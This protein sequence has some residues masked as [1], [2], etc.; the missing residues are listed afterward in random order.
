MSRTATLASP[1]AGSRTAAVDGDSSGPLSALFFSRTAARGITVISHRG[2]GAGAGAGAGVG[3]RGRAGSGAVKAIPI[4]GP[5]L[6]GELAQTRCQRLPQSPCSVQD[7]AAA[8]GI[9]GAFTYLQTKGA[10]EIYDGSFDAI[11]KTFKNKGVLDFYS[12]AYDIGSVSQIQGVCQRRFG[13]HQAETWW[14]ENHEK[15]Y[16]K[17]NVRSTDKSSV[18]PP[19]SQH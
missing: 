15:V 18:S 5:K 2:N 16:D 1:T 17:Y 8:G 6:I 12:E 19:S 10:S 7:A 9:A 4:P 14:S 13:E 3:G 11:V